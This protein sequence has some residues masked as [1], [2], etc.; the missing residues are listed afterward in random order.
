MM[1]YALYVLGGLAAIALLSRIPG[2]DLLLKPFGMVAGDF[3]R[4]LASNSGNFLV[5]MVK[6][7]FSC[8]VTIL[9]HLTHSEEHFNV[10]LAMKKEIEGG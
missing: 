1:L 2:I 6:A 7:F 10:E 8:H 4:W 3:T 9:R 5:Y